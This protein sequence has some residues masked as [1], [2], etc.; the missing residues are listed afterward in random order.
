MTANP[1]RKTG[2][3]AK[4]RS[5]LATNSPIN[6]TTIPDTATMNLILLLMH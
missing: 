6:T 5:K 4:A 1:I 2:L 3:V